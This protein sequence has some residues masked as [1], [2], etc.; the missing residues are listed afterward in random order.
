MKN[1]LASQGRQQGLRLSRNCIKEYRMKRPKPQ[2]SKE[3]K[4]IKSLLFYGDNLEV[5]RRKIKD[6]TIDL[7]YID[8][9]F[10]SKRNYNQIYNNVGS[11]DRAQAQAFVDTW[12][13]DDYAITGFSEIIINDR[14]RFQ[15]KLIDLIKGLRQVLGE[16]DLLAY[17]VNMSLRFTEIH[18]VLK[19]TG[20]LYLHCDPT[21]SHYLKII[22]DAIFCS[23]GGDFKNEIVWHYTGGGRS[24]KYFSWKHDI[25]FCYSKTVSIIFNVDKIRVP[26]KETSGYAK[27]GIISRVGKQYMPNPEGTPVDD[28][29]NIPIINPLSKE[30]LGYPTQ[31]PETLLERI[32]EASSNEGD[33]VLDA[34]CG[35]GTTVVV[36]QDLKRKW[37]GIDITYQSISLVL[38]RLE[39][40]FGNEI[41]SNIKTDG[42]PKDMESAKAL[43]LKNDDRTRKEFEK[44]SVLTYTN[45]RAVINEKKGA[46]GGIDARSHFAARSSKDSDKI[47][48]QVKSGNVGRKDIAAFRGDIAREEAAMGIYITLNEPTEPMIKEAKKAGKYYHE[49]MRCEYDKIRI[50]T[51][52]EI[53][54]DGKRLDIPLSIEVLKEAEKV[55]KP[56]TMGLFNEYKKI[57]KTIQDK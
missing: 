48:Y 8:P 36:A 6:E 46:D 5:L 52:K 17:L 15:P 54:E 32:I 19:S 29:W 55:N 57:D 3:E 41:L 33:I 1:Q 10:N 44:W 16:G 26:Y 39:D 47:V 42:I 18:R 51:I 2:I 43:A 30:R 56:K 37:I 20:S 25:I 7:C 23:Q 45:N 13:W 49:L 12:K 35:C 14:G 28:V 11:E 21:A 22:L 27:S 34:Y 53:I 9:P 31:K 4:S 24:K 38:K 40:K 50:I